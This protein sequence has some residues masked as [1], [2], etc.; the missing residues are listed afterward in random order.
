LHLALGNRWKYFERHDAG[1]HLDLGDVLAGHGASSEL[2]LDELCGLVPHGLNW[3]CPPCGTRALRE[4]SAI[5]D[6][7]LRFLC[8][9]GRMSEKDYG[10]ASGEMAMIARRDFSS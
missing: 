2:S 7:L 8:V 5:F 6:L 4:S 1:W 3:Q 10:A 9:T